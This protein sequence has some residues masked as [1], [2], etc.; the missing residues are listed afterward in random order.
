MK[1]NK[2]NKLWLCLFA[3]A[4]ACLVLFANTAIANAANNNENKMYTGLKAI[5]PYTHQITFSDFEYDSDLQTISTDKVFGCSSVRNGNYYGRNFDYIYNDT[6]EFVVRMKASDERYASIGVAQHWGLREADLLAKSYDKQ[7]ELVPNLT[8]DGINEN[9]VVA[10]INVVPRQDVAEVT[11]TNPDGEKLHMLHMV[12]YILDNAASATEAVDLLAGRNIYGDLGDKYLHL[13]VA[14]EK[15]TYIVEF[16]DNKLVAKEKTGNEQIMTNY[17]NNLDDYTE[18]AMGV[19][20]YQILQNNYDMSNSVEGMFELLQK[21]S[22][23]NIGHMDV[24]NAWC[25][26]SGMSRTEINT[27][28]RSE[29]QAFVN[30]FNK[31]YFE[32]RNFESKRAEANPSV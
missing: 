13:M 24:D 17:Y 2:L 8:L 4:A 11:G 16:L 3:I 5:A 15:K 32:V 25:S 21:V 18:H 20:R 28:P 31:K 10:N 14:D 9:G 1:I 27:I 23:N 22:F 6:P 29:A 26:D 7:L 12:R 30:N 19:E